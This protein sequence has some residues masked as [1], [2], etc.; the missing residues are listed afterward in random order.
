[1]SGGQHERDEREAVRGGVGEFGVGLDLV[2]RHGVDA[3]AERHEH[4]FLAPHD[5]LGHAGGAARV[6]HVVVVT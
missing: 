4:V 2:P 5:S 1:M 3:L 6:E